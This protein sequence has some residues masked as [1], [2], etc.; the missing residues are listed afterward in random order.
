MTRALLQVYLIRL[1]FTLEIQ[2]CYQLERCIAEILI[3]FDRMKTLVAHWLRITVIV[4]HPLLRFRSFWLN[5]EKLFSWTFVNFLDLKK[6]SNFSKKFEENS[7]EFTKNH[8]KSRKYSIKSRPCL[9][10][11]TSNSYGRLTKNQ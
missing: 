8:E 10:V 6:I 11:G 7:R 3:G 4:Q 1:Q 2:I 5:F 9:T